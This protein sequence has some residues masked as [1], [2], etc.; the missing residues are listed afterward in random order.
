MTTLNSS[1]AYLLLAHY[2]NS[3]KLILLSKFSS[4]HL[5]ILSKSSIFYKFIKTSDNIKSKVFKCLMDLMHVKCA[6]FFFS[7]IK[8]L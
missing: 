8:Y 6:I 1:F 3:L 4:T 2:L 5:K 7:L